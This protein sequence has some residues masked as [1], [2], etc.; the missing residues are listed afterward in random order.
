[1][2][3]S[4]IRTERMSVSPS[5]LMSPPHPHWGSLPAGGASF[6]CRDTW[7]TTI[8]TCRRP[9]PTADTFRP[10]YSRST[11]AAAGWSAISAMWPRKRGGSWWASPKA[12]TH[13]AASSRCCF[14]GPSCST[15]STTCGSIPTGFSSRGCPAAAGPHLMPP[16]SMLPWWPEF[17]PWVAGWGTNTQPGATFIYQACW[18]PGQTG[19]M[20]PA[21]TTTWRPTATT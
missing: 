9:T 3:W 6:Q 4:R 17:F 12:G 15:C 10:C 7:L 21:R 20:T 19:T 2:W 13:R 5:H 14:P 18:S 11:R 8:S 1:M 16:R